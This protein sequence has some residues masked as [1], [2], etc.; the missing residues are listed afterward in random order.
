M[1]INPRNL[2]IRPGHGLVAGFLA[3][4]FCCASVFLGGIITTL[5]NCSFYSSSNH[6]EQLHAVFDYKKLSAEFWAKFKK[7]K[8]DA[9]TA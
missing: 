6:K 8:G 9:I 1:G 2:T 4:T 7:L 3:T 5:N